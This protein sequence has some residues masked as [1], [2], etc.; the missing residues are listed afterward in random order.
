M[1]LYVFNLSLTTT[2]EGLKNAFSGYGQVASAKVIMDRFAGK[3]KGFGFVEMPDKQEAG[4]AIAE[5]NNGLVD[6]NAISVIEA[7]PREER[8]DRSNNFRNDSS[9]YNKRRW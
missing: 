7:R 4:K 8:S 1:N 5:L 9:L 6:G 2:D 3:S